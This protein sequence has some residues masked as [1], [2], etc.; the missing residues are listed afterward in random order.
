MIQFNGSVQLPNNSPKTIAELIVAAIAARAYTSAQAKTDARNRLNP[1][2][3][4]EGF[5]VAVGTNVY[6]SDAYK[7]VTNGVVDAGV[8]AAGDFTATPGGGELLLAGDNR[9]FNNGVDLGSRV[10]FQAS[11]APVTLYFDITIH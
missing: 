8:W 4:R 2:I 3:V 9:H 1:A 5:M 6:M 10:L 7:G 11:G